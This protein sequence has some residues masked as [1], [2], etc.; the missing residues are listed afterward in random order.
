MIPAF[1]FLIYG[2]F[3]ISSLA[4]FMYLETCL[5]YDLKPHVNLAFGIF[6]F[7]LF[8]YTYHRLVRIRSFSE[9]QG[10]ERQI[11]IREHA[12]ILAWV[13]FI[14]LACASWILFPN[15]NRLLLIKCIPFLLLTLVYVFPWP[16]KSAGWLG[17]R[18]IPYLK[19]FLISAVWTFST[20]VFPFLFEDPKWE[21]DQGQWM[22]IFLRGL[23]FMA[24]TLPFDIRDMHQDK[25]NNIKTFASLLGIQGLKKIC[26][27]FLIA[28]IILAFFSG[29][30]GFIR[31]S[32][33][34]G[35]LVSGLSTAWVV[36]MAGAER[37]E[38][39]YLGLL[40]GMIADQLFWV[41][42]MGWLS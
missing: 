7:T 22:G 35:L 27:L 14:A 18:N 24:V 11:W 28:F 8:A 15:I 25:Q 10:S 13:S 36:N 16:K 20:L 31:S 40:D 19:V 23:F 12:P 21:P 34:L 41:W 29:H 37:T 39:Y 4:V 30:L 26:H 5:L 32:H 17:F 1:R 6:C 42:L 3:W 9:N 33:A 2:N 38:V